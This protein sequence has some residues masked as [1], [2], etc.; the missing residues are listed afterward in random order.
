MSD[1]VFRPDTSYKSLSAI[2]LPV[3]GLSTTHIITAHSLLLEVQTTHL[4]SSSAFLF[5]QLTSPSVTENG[6]AV[7]NEDSKPKADVVRDDERVHYFRGNTKSLL[8]A[9]N[10]DGVDIRGYLAWSACPL[11]IDAQ[12]LKY[13]RSPGQFRMVRCDKRL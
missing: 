6:F 3:E 11:S 2:E 10:E 1:L 5:A 9:L 8:A 7:K 4:V 13:H 12:V